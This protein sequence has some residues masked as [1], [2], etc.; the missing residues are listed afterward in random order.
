MNTKEILGRKIID[1]NATEIAK[2]SEL[3]FDIDTYKIVKIYGSFGNPISKK[4]YPIGIEDIIALGEYLLINKSASQMESE[5]LD[6]IP[7]SSPHQINLN[8]NVGKTV[9]DSMGNV[10]GKISDIEINIDEFKVVALTVKKSSSFSRSRKEY[11]ITT[12]DIISNGDYILINKVLGDNGESSKDN[13]DDTKDKDDSSTKEEET[14][15][16]IDIN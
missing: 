11:V 16:T 8:N 3:V 13:K 14:R 6:K 2:I 12:D 10:T 15:Q 7:D 1:V 4:Y 5:I 9:L